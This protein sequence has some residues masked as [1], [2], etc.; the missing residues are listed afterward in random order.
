VALTAGEPVRVQ[1]TSFATALVSGMLAILRNQNPK[2]S[3]EEIEALLVD[4]TQKMV[5]GV[6]VARYN[7][8]NLVD[9]ALIP[10][11]PPVGLIE[12]DIHA[13]DMSFISIGHQPIK[14]QLLNSQILDKGKVTIDSTSKPAFGG[15]TKLNADETITFTPRE[16]FFGRDYF[17]YILKDAQGKLSR[18][19]V[20]TILVKK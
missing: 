17:T 8:T 6:A 4:G 16:N 5:D 19:G 18:R 14:I 15:I 9:A 10:L 3:L 11:L 20:V 1:G 2:A 13:K 12:N 7:G